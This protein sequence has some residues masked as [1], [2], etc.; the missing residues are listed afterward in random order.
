MPKSG[1]LWTPY[2]YYLQGK[3]ISLID[4]SPPRWSY[5]MVSPFVGPSHTFQPMKEKV[6]TGLLGFYDDGHEP[7]IRILIYKLRNKLLNILPK[8][9]SGCTTPSLIHHLHHG[10]WKKDSFFESSNPYSI[11]MSNSSWVAIYLPQFHRTCQFFLLTL[12]DAIL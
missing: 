5:L 8:T 12:I 3:R 7:K 11:S 9:K 4:S 1:S 10:Q 6:Q 2:L